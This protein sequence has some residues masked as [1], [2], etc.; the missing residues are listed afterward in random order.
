MVELG[1]TGGGSSSM[2]SDGTRRRLTTIT[3]KRS[4]SPRSTSSTRT[5]PEGEEASQS[6]DAE[7]CTQEGQELGPADLGVPCHS[8]A[9]SQ[10]PCGAVW[11]QSERATRP[12]R[13]WAS[14]HVLGPPL[15]DEEEEG[16]ALLFTFQW[17]SSD[18]PRVRE[19]WFQR[20]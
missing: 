8:L 7:D 16:V 12:V 10:A 13:P 14:D 17:S 19:G 1:G 20:P 4:A 18:D 2:T 9:L 5:L 3:R 15:A 11:D 6:Q